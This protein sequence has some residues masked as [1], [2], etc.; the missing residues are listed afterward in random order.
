[1]YK[2]YILLLIVILIIVLGNL[3]ITRE[4]FGVTSSIS[5]PDECTF[6]TDQVD[7]ECNK[8]VTEVGDE[9][10]VH[11]VCPLNP[12]C[13]GTCI[14]DFT[15]TADNKIQL[16]Q[17]DKHR[18]NVGELKSNSPKFKAIFKSSRCMECIKN[19]HTGVRLMND[20]SQCVLLDTN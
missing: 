15:W 7:S 16:G 19:F 12:K 4:G 14:N 8:I 13:V 11:N 5:Q 20:N 3:F 17:F 6:T 2:V 18:Y 1:M 9:F 10:K